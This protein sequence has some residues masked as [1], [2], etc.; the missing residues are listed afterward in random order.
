MFGPP[1]ATA[2]VLVSLVVLVLGYY[3][4]VNLN[5]GTLTGALRWGLDVNR[6]GRVGFSDVK[7][8]TARAYSFVFGFVSFEF[9]V[10][11]LF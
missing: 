5:W 9:G 6:D 2:A 1:I 4:Y 3:G 8:I 7:A 10:C 11:C